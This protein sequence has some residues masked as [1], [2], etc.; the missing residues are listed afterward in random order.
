MKHYINPRAVCPLYK[1]ENP[2]MVYCDGM[3]ICEESV[4]HIAFSSR[5]SAKKYKEDYCY[6]VDNYNNCQIYKMLNN[7]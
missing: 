1:H 2:P 6:S 7:I 5:H 4:L 3:G